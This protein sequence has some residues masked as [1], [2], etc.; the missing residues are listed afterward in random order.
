RTPLTSIRGNIGL[1]QHEPPIS[2]ED[3]IAVLNDTQEECERLIRLVNDLLTLARADTG[4]PLR[5]EPV[6]IKPLLEDVCRM[7]QMLNPARRVE[8]NHLLDIE[9]IGDRDAIRQIVLILIDNA[10]KF[11]P[12]SGNI[13]ATMEAGD[14]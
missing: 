13:T 14:G 10:L 12:P 8:C 7:V 2:D 11:T 9:A 6:Q 5:S 4:R 1:L 3:R